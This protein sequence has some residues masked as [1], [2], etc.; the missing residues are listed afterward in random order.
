MKRTLVIGATG[1]VGRQVV[2][3]LAAN[4]A[5]VRALAR[6]PDTADLP[7]QVEVMRGNLTIP[8]T[9]DRCLDGVDAVFL[10]WTAPRPATEAAL[11]RIAKRAR[12]IVFLSAPLKTPHPFFQQPNPARD[13][14]IQIEQYIESS[15]LEWTFLRPGMF[16]ANSRHFWGP[17]I[18]SSDTVRWPHLSCCTAP[19]DERDIAAVAVRALTEDGHAGMEYV[20]TGPQSLSQREQISTIG[21]AIGR[22]LNIEEI[23]PEEARQ[24]G[25][26][27]P[28]AAVNMLLDAWAAASGLPAYVTST[29]GEITGTPAR[30]LLDWARDNA[31]D[32]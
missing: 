10:V 1:T 16:A 17:Q 8:D 19:I 25:L 9:L 3:Q 6:N 26:G 21:A 32:F 14:A 15:G 12:C 18:R 20:I 13:L 23:S 24:S 29:V 7:P 22:T 30:T 31:S 2:S 4:G 11:E 28:P 5:P 27:M